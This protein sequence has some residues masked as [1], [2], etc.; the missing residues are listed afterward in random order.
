MGPILALDGRERIGGIADGDW[1]VD[2]VDAEGIG[3]IGLEMPGV[4]KALVTPA[5]GVIE[6]CFN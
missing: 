1:V 4:T 3:V 5:P 2:V 6:P